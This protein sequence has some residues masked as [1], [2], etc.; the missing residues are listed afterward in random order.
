MDIYTVNVIFRY[1]KG[2]TIALFPYEINDG[3]GNVMSYMHIG[4][5]SG[6]DYT[7]I[8]KH[9]KPATLEQYT[10]LYVELT[11]IGYNLK[12]IKKINHNTWSTVWSKFINE[13]NK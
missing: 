12:I 7:H 3:E 4:Q 5:H 8:I 11:G 2:E 6:A 10:D 1:W 13:Y 9:S